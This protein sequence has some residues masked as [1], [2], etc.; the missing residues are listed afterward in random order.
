MNRKIKSLVTM[1][2]TLGLTMV[3][4]PQSA[5]AYTVPNVVRVGLEGVCKNKTTA[6]LGGSTLLVGTEKDG[7]FREDREISS[8][9]G[10]SVSLVSGEYIAIDENMDQAEAS[11]LANS[12]IRMGLSAYLTYLGNDNWTVYVANTSLSEV[13][14]A[15]RCNATR[16]RDFV[17]IRMDGNKESVLFPK[18]LKAVF[19]G[20][21]KGD[22]FVL[23]GNN[24]RGM[25]SFAINGAV[26]T[27]VN[28]VGLEDY[29]YG[30]V[31]SEMPQSYEMEA[32]KA[33]TI[34]ARTYAM[35]KLSTHTSYG[36][37]LC[38]GINC[39]VYK[40]YSGEATRTSQAVDETEGEVACYN[41]KPIEAVFSAS[42]G[43]Y[44]ENSENVW[45]NVVPYL[46]AVPE[47]AEDG[48]NAWTVTLTLDDLDVLLDKKGENLGTAQDIVIT[49]L[50]TGGRVQEMQIV[51]SRGT[52]TLTK[53]D[54][55]TYFSATSSGSLPGKMFT[56]NGKGGEIGVYRVESGKGQSN[57]QTSP[58]K[59]GSLASAAAKNGIVA[60]TEGALSSI[61]GKT[62]TV[63]GGGS[64]SSSNNTNSN[65]SEDYEVYPVNIST[66]DNS[67]RFVFEG[68]GRGHG[69]GLSQKGAQSM[70]KL[71]YTYDE[72][73]KH[74]YTGIT[75]E[76]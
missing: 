14:S 29:L 64:G 28:I 66:V 16:V 11:D 72:I 50:S 19:M 46:R 54:I 37:Q 63:V 76:G 42:T 15:S 31:P 52:K 44:T 67:G 34:A 1:A 9:S 22:T 5:F 56:I 48:N 69:V 58:T 57:N 49:K 6:N 33:Q 7:N 3:A 71:G 62:I 8:S 40:G 47:I 65:P 61:D 13:E 10:F 25:L 68:V 39:Q 26:M 70:A 38:D 60:K 12:L 18:D 43:G 55:R 27:A 53:E 24:Y 75:I 4:M 2:L 35:T 21:E 41:G 59:G 73:L 45:Y 32:L 17:G 51:G 30:V 20:T 74:Y 36:Y 23:N